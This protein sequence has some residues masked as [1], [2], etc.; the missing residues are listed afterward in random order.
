MKEQLF[1][2]IF[3]RLIFSVRDVS[4]A[5]ESFEFSLTAAGPKSSGRSIDVEAN[6]HAHGDFALS[7]HK[8]GVA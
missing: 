6:R 4:V 8:E 3:C 1:N 5:L 2:L 7:V